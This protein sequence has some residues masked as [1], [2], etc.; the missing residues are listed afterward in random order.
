ML[1]AK[2]GYAGQGK[3]NAKKGEKDHRKR[4]SQEPRKNLGTPPGKQIHGHRGKKKTANFEEKKDSRQ[5]Y[6]KTKKVD[7]T[8]H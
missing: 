7:L 5:A 3:G 6:Q 4:D 1:N 2:R 8:G